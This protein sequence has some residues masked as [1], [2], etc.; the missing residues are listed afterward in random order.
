MK[1]QEVSQEA[2]RIEKRLKKDKQLS[3]VYKKTLKILGEKEE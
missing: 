1:V 2:M 3:D